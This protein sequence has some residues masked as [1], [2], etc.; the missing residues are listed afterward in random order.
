MDKEKRY[1]NGLVDGVF[2]QAIRECN[3]I[4]G[5]I[6]VNDQFQV[7]KFKDL[8]RRFIRDNARPVKISIERLEDGNYE[9]KKYTYNGDCFNTRWFHTF[10]TAME[11]A[12]MTF[13]E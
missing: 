9:I 10:Y 7:D 11:D 2:N 5:D 3:L 12:K 6:N 8:I 13:C 4:N 1:V